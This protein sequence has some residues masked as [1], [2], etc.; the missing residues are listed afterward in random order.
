[1]DINW[2]AVGSAAFTAIR[3]DFPVTTLRVMALGG[4]D[5]PA[6]GDALARAKDALGKGAR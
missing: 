5:T 1:M 4:N 6:S 2:Y 3:M